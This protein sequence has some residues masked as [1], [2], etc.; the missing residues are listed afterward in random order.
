M[1][2]TPE[3]FTDNSPIS[4]GPTMIVKHFSSRK[5]LYLFTEVLDVKKKIAVRWVGA[6]K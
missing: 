5:S 4:T 6:A 3:I 2:S 1:V